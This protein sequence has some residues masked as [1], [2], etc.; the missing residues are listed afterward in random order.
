MKNCGA[1]SQTLPDEARFCAR[2][3]APQAAAPQVDD[4]QTMVMT[5]QAPMPEVPAHPRPVAETPAS[6]PPGAAP[7]PDAARR[8]RWKPLLV[9]AVLGVGVAGA[10]AALYALS[11]ADGAALSGATLLMDAN[12]DGSVDVY[13]VDDPDLIPAT[14]SPADRILDNVQVDGRYTVATGD[15]VARYSEFDL[16]YEGGALFSYRPEASEEWILAI[17]T[18]RQVDEIAR[19]DVRPSAWF[20]DAGVYAGTEFAE[21]D[22]RCSIVKLDGMQ[23]TRLIDGDVCRLDAIAE[24]VVVGER[25]QSRMDL[26][27]LNLSNEALTPLDVDIGIGGLSLVASSSGRRVL[28]SAN[29]EQPQSVLLDVRTGDRVAGTSLPGLFPSDTGYVAS[30]TTDDGGV[31]LFAVSVAGQRE[32]FSGNDWPTIVLS[33]SGRSMAM[34]EHSEGAGSTLSLVSMADGDVEPVR[35][36]SSAAGAAF[37][38]DDRLLVATAD[39]EISIVDG[40]EVTEI[41]N[42]QTGSFTSAPIV[43]TAG[44]ID[45]IGFDT[46]NGGSVAILDPGGRESIIEVATVGRLFQFVTSSDGRWVAMT[47]TGGQDGTQVLTTVDLRT[48][49]VTAVDEYQLAQEMQ[50]L[51]DS[52]YYHAR[53][54]S[55]SGQMEARR[56]ILGEQVEIEV[57]G[58]GFRVMVPDVNSTRRR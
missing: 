23:A 37:L 10:L 22:G 43:G 24:V 11:D 52:L 19:F 3:G 35:S 57:L 40:D 38:D 50:F 41:A 13:V 30:E 16:A 27:M 45:W 9:L 39:G 25:K 46:D 5:S 42:L 51:G 12:D 7:N 15:G 56:A 4:Q 6:F 36:F 2:C 8:A 28:I 31:R 1:C 29:T 47:N 26:S 58:R 55:G 48:K 53:P 54:L 18:D 14:P 20:L 49:K 33:P 17:V 21:G 44:P 34:V 32:L